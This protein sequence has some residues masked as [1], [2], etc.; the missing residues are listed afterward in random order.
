M[1]QPYFQLRL[2]SSLMHQPALVELFQTQFGSSPSA[3]AWFVVSL[4]L[5]RPNEAGSY[6]K[7]TSITLQSSSILKLK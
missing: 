1:D 3:L 7:A 5:L 2:F 4:L 6:D